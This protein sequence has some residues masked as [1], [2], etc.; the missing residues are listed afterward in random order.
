MLTGIECFLDASISQLQDLHH[1][2]LR[3]NVDPKVTAHLFK[4]V[5]ECQAAH[6]D[7]PSSPPSPSITKTISKLSETPDDEVQKKDNINKNRIINRDLHAALL[8]WINQY[9]KSYSTDNCKRESLVHRRFKLRA[10]QKIKDTTVPLKRDALWYSFIYSYMATIE[11]KHSFD[12]YK[13]DQV[14]VSFSCHLYH[15]KPYKSKVLTSE[16]TM[17]NPG[18]PEV[19]RYCPRTISL[20]DYGR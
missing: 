12:K 3:A 1:V 6:P 15:G 18:F 14:S 4:I 8:E 7:M 2:C 9:V 20:T 16:Y 11:K 19:Y 10:K 5:G 13:K 17:K